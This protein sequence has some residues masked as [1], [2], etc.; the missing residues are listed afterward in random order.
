MIMPVMRVWEVDV[1]VRQLFMLVVMAVLGLRIDGSV[2]SMLV[3]GVMDMLVFML[4]G[5][6]HV[7]VHVTLS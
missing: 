6:V 5:F 7:F 4:N 1:N 3:V 2:V